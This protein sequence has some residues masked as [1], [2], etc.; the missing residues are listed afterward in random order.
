MENSYEIYDQEGEG[1]WVVRP[2][3]RTNVWETDFKQVRKFQA[4]EGPMLDNIEINCTE[5]RFAK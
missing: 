4:E 1:I 3:T 2:G 5:L